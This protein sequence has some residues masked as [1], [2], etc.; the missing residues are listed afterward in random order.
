[1]TSFTVF[2]AKKRTRKLQLNLHTSASLGGGNARN[3]KCE[4]TLLR[5]IVVV[6]NS[7][8]AFCNSDVVAAILNFDFGP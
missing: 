4:F 3:G 8:L 7:I 1:V 2:F 5:Y 6:L